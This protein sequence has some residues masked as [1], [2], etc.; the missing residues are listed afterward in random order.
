MSKNFKQ[1][2]SEA[3][4]WPKI[5]RNLTKKVNGQTLVGV[6]NKNG[7][8]WY[9]PVAKDGTPVFTNTDYLETLGPEYRQGL[10][11]A[12]IG[13]PKKADGE[14]GKRDGQWMSFKDIK[15]YTKT[16]KANSP[17]AKAERANFA[18]LKAAGVDVGAAISAAKSG[19]VP[20]PRIKTLDDLMGYLLKTNNIKDATPDRYQVTGFGHNPDDD[21]MD[22]KDISSFDR[23][24]S[25]PM[26]AAQDLLKTLSL[27][28]PSSPTSPTAPKRPTIDPGKSS[29]AIDSGDTAPSISG[30]KDTKLIDPSD[31]GSEITM[32]DGSKISGD[33]T[34]KRTRTQNLKDLT[35]DRLA[36]LAGI[37]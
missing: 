19:K 4:S 26:A 29:A 12:G 37:K 21:G 33:R 2:L 30:N 32:P 5:R 20:D 7:S 6:E 25:D 13:I 34:T 3:E 28:T 31:R 15:D 35:R 1:Y 36:K 11:Q 9:L 17:L 23:G 10:E 14:Y 18:A 24:T 8:V 27:R 22:Y 16:A